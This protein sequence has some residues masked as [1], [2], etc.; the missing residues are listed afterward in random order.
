[1]QQ[2]TPV[3]PIPPEMVLDA[4]NPEERY[5]LMRKMGAKNME[6]PLRP[7]S[8]LINPKTGVIYPWNPA[9]AEQRDILVN[10]DAHGNTDPATWESTVQE[11]RAAVDPEAQAKSAG[12]AVMV[13]VIREAAKPRAAT[14][15]SAYDRYLE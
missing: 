4:E 3:T 6:P 13:Q 11:A 5:A 1:M 2:A 7:S 12:D 15:A 8:H 14:D 9:L 10:C